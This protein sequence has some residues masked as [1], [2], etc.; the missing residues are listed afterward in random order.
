MLNRRIL[1]IKA[2]KALYSFAE[3]PSLSLPELE[4]QFGQS[5]EA[6][7]SLYLFMLAVIPALTAEARVRT[8]EARRK[9]HPTEAERNPNLKFVENTLS[10]LIEEDPDFQKA[11]GS[12]KLSWDQYDVFLHA[13]YESVRTK[14]YYAAYMADPVR[15]LSADVQL[16][17]RIFEDCFVDDGA[18]EKILEDLSI[19]WNDDLAYALTCCC[20]TLKDFQKGRRWS[21]PPL[22][23]SEMTGAADDDRAFAYRLLRSSYANYGTF[24]ALA[25]ERVPKWEKERLFTTDMVLVVMGLSEA[26]AFPQM[27]LRVTIN[28]YVEISKYYSTPKSRSFVNGLLDSLVRALMAEGEI[29]KADSLDNA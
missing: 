5:C 7:R 26:K 13:L 12:L 24:S 19:W 29:V 28:E 1:R 4:A 2:F 25:A 21:L 9:F 11:F 14:D 22:Y 6:T 20:D 3:D 15:S 27:P 16:F 8:G 23:R 17:I 10:R 18:L